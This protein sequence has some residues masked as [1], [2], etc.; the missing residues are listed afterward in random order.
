MAHLL[1]TEKPLP[2]TKRVAGTLLVMLTPVP[3]SVL[4][5]MAPFLWLLL[6][7]EVIRQR[8]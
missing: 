4:K 3:L 6:T 2:K 7:G 8:D 5:K 1:Q